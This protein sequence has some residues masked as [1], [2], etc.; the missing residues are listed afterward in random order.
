M[1]H[2]N[3][4]IKIFFCF[5]NFNILLK[6]GIFFIY[7]FY[8]CMIRFVAEIYFLVEVENAEIWQLVHQIFVEN[9][10]LTLCSKQFAHNKSLGKARL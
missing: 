5:L 8:F 3:F 6:F 10:T 7:F 2:D 9:D 1:V 4:L